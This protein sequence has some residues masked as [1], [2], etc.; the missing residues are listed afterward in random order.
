M[1]VT[2]P[3]FAPHQDSV[4][5]LHDRVLQKMIDLGL[6]TAPTTTSYTKDVY[7]ILQRARDMR[8]VEGIF[9]AHTWAD[10]VTSQPVVDAIVGRLRP[11][12][13]MP[14]LNGSDSALTPTQLAHMQRWQA[15]SYTN[16]WT[17]VPA[18]ETAI[19]PDGL[20][21][22]A[23]EACVGGA[24][25]PG[26][27]AGGLSAGDRPI[28]EAPYAAAFRLASSVAPGDHQQV[29]WRCRGRPTSR[30][31]ATTGGRSRVPTTSSPRTP[32]ARPAG[33]RDVGSM[34]DMVDLWHTLGFVV[35]AG[36]RAR[37]GRALRRARRST[38]SPRTCASPTCR[39]GRWAWC[40][41]R[42]WR[43][44][45]R[46]SPRRS[47]VTLEYAPAGHRRT[48]SWSRS[49]RR[50]PSARPPP[51]RSPP[52]GSVVI[53][54]TG[55][56]PSSI[57]Q[58]VLTVPRGGRHQTWT[59]TDRRRTPSPARPRPPSLVLDRS[60]QHERGPRRRAEQ[61]RLPPAGRERSSS[62]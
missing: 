25:F 17:G 61:A 41:R 58:Q 57:P 52:P 50:S 31:A 2:P 54:R 3:K 45:S 55:T 60:G 48:R 18:P 4:T 24:F 62:T 8:W 12:G 27:E 26:I 56:A 28:L 15:G 59:V 16:D 5:T 37:R 34:D 7:P 35:R 47:A 32:G 23:L 20:D 44:P 9:G 14:A 40:A 22:A 1:L 39:R 46:S 43:S 19:T 49:R 30:P 42:C 11:A 53:Y 38:C 21:R 33:T 13:N 10:P 6:A 36:G 51:T 29:R